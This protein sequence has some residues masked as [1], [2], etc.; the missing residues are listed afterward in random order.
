MAYL[1]AGVVLALGYDSIVQRLMNPR[2]MDFFIGFVIGALL[3]WVAVRSRSQSGVK[4]PEYGG[5][6]T[7]ASAFGTGAVVN[8]IGIP[9]ALPYFAALDQ[10]LKSDLSVTQ[11]LGMLAAYNLLYAL[12]FAIVPV[13]SAVYGEQSRHLLQRINASLG[14]VSAYLMPFLL[15]VVGAA[16]IADAVKYFVTGKG[17]F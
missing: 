1:S 15:A 10:I 13:L 6:L 17:L 2:H 16:L 14:R 3:L 4:E 12:P 7:P 11:A 8:F 9:F 5:E